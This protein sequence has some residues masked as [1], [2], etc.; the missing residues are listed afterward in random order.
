M[1]VFLLA[2]GRWLRLSSVPMPIENFP[3][4]IGRFIAS[5]G[6]IELMINSAIKE[7]STDLLLAHEICKLRLEPRIEI[8]DKLLKERRTTLSASDLTALSGDLKSI[9]KDRNAVA[10]NPIA[11]DDEQDSNPRILVL[12]HNRVQTITEAELESMHERAEKM[13]LRLGQVIPP[14]E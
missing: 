7:L 8:L 14:L 2:F 6:A 5:C 9:A 13:I 3:T 11:S 4:L 1:L 12:R 10:H